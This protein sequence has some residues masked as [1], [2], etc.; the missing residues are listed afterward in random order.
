MYDLL[1]TQCGF[2]ANHSTIHALLD[3][4]TSYDNISNSKFT[5]L[6]LLDLRK[7]FDTVNHSILLNKLEQYGICGVAHK[8]FS[9]FLSNRCPM[10]LYIKSNPLAR[11]LVVVYCKAPFLVHYYL[12]CILIIL[13]AVH[14]IAFNCLLMVPI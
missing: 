7:A 2:K 10:Y 11:K 4:I 3:I 13:T 12:R 9:S 6:V 1:P 8:L 14:L 5:A